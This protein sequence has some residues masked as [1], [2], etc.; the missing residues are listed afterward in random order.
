MTTVDRVGSGPL[1]GA[2][3]ERTAT[4]IGPDLRAAVDRLSGSVRHVAGYQLGWWDRDGVATGGAGGKGFRPAL[5]LLSAQ[6]VAVSHSWSTGAAVAV[7]LVHN[8]TLLHDD[9]MDGDLTLDT[10]RRRG[11][12][13][14]GLRPCSLATRCW[15]WAPTCSSSGAP[16][17]RP[18][19]CGR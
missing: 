10:G 4:L 1:A 16:R 18:S 12:C 5:T 7:E 9:I 6:A 17:G 3:L 2:P 15:C 11:L 19:R 8:F 13:A 14:G